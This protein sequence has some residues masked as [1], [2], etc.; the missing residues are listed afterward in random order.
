MSK[1]SFASSRAYMRFSGMAVQMG[2]IISC[3]AFLGRWAD[4]YWGLPKIGVVVGSL[5]GVG[6]ALYIFIK[7]TSNPDERGNV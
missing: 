7:Q 4:S 1:K 6:I 2:L 5:L 3:L